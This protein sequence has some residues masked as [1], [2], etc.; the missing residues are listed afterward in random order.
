MARTAATLDKSIRIADLMSV[1]LIAKTFPL[2]KVRAV[3]EAT[4]K[5]SI[6]ERNLP[7]HVVVYYVVA[8]VENGTHV[9]FAAKMA[10]CTTSE[11]ALA[12]EVVPALRAGML[13]LADRGFFSY[14]MWNL[15]RANGADLLWRIKKITRLICEERLPDGSY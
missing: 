4:G 10:G 8:L 14:P 3:L 5:T 15:A 2:S 6:R 11:I 7:A 12:K 9:M 1:S 13:G